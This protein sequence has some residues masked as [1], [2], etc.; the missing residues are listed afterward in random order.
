MEQNHIDIELFPLVF[1]NNKFDVH[2]FYF[3]EIK[4]D[5]EDFE[6]GLLDGLYK[7]E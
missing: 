2:K 4:F 1:E 5:K 6:C 3:N 7:L